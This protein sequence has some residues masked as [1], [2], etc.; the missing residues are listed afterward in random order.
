MELMSIFWF[1]AGVLWKARELNLWESIRLSILG[2]RLTSLILGCRLWC[3]LSTL[4]RGKNEGVSRSFNGLTTY[5]T[6][7]LTHSSIYRTWYVRLHTRTYELSRSV[8]S[9]PAKTAYAIPQ[10]ATSRIATPRWW[11]YRKWF[12]SGLFCLSYRLT[13][14]RRLILLL[15]TQ[16]WCK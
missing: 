7:R 8:T 11:R 1:I 5:A 12:K 15:V 14:S 13:L 10:N 6:V 4:L 9:W 2:R 3:L 16:T